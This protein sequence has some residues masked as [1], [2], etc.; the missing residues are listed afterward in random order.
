MPNADHAPLTHVMPV[1]VNPASGAAPDP[2]AAVAEVVFVDDSGKPTDAPGGGSGELDDGSVTTSKLADGAVTSEKIAS[3][4][5][6]EEYV[7]PAASSSA[8]GG[9]KQGSAISDISAAPTQTDFNGLLAVLR[10]TGILA[11]S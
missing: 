6:P 8:L 1:H 4:V 3:G 5:I 7:L 2:N 9:V 11:S 10:A